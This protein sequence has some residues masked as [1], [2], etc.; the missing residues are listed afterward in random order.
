MHREMRYAAGWLEICFNQYFW[1]SIKSSRS[2]S[3]RSRALLPPSPGLPGRWQV[4]GRG[5][6][7]SGLTGRGSVQ[8]LWLLPRW[9]RRGWRWWL[10]ISW[11][12]L[13]VFLISWLRLLVNWQGL[14][15]INLTGANLLSLD[16][17]QRQILTVALTVA[18][19]EVAGIPGG[20]QGLQITMISSYH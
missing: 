10:F 7:G 2:W 14:S 19:S 20:L 3:P 11:L 18:V 5:R 6:G 12:R 15:I 9:W 8:R 4:G 1:F 13:L 16:G 17:L